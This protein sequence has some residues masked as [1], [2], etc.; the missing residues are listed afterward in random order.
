MA[1]ASDGDKDVA[2]RLRPLVYEQ[3][4]K[5]AQ[6]G[7]AGKRLGHTLSATTLVHEA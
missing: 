1:A 6:L 5:A 7:L 3:L 4:R 2:A